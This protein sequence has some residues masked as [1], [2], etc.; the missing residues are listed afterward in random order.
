MT[1][2]FTIWNYIF[3][4]KNNICTMHLCISHLTFRSKYRKTLTFTWKIFLYPTKFVKYPVVP[5]YKIFE[6]PVLNLNY[7]PLTQWFS[8][9]IPWTSSM[10]SAAKR[11]S[12]ITSHVNKDG[13]RQNC[14]F[15]TYQN[16]SDVKKD[17]EPL[18][19]WLG[20]QNIPPIRVF[21]HT[22][23]NT[24]I[25]RLTFNNIP[26]KHESKGKGLWPEVPEHLLMNCW[27]KVTIIISTANCKC[28][29]ITRSK[30]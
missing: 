22:I 10:C 30:H 6:S 28:N 25:P 11:I 24:W 4:D 21:L 16:C 13:V 8:I 15:S 7:I 27:R 19:N 23:Y 2:D 18:L 14:P 17:R 26:V 1:T 9:R 20:F 12:L 29:V 3:C 5:N